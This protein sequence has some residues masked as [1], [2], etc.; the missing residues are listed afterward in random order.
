ESFFI[1]NLENIQGDE[2]DVIFIS[3]TYGPDVKTGRIF[4]R[5]GPINS[6]DGWRR[7]NVL[8]TR[9]KQRLVLF[10]S[11][12]STDIQDSS[13][14]G[15]KILKSYLEYAET[16][17]LAKTIK[18]CDNISDFE[19]VISKIL[20]SNGYQT[21]SQIGV[22]GIDIGVLHQDKENEYI[23]GIEYDGANYHTAKSIRDRDRLRTEM[24]TNKGWKIHRIWSVDWFKNR[25]TEINRL[26]Q[27]L[28]EHKLVE[29]KSLP[30]CSDS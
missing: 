17:H 15:V 23:L 2:R 4:Q 27:A 7:L 20:H 18:Q 21:V 1:K 3:I 5:F 29:I 24:L 6:D 13:K 25:E 30:Q 22:N 26:L 16:G 10:S 14:Q 19:F 12:H 9:A 28:S 11:L 8:F